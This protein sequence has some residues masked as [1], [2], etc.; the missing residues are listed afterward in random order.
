MSRQPVSMRQA[1]VDDV[2][3]LVELWADGLRRADRQEQVSDLELIVK[4]AEES[5]ERR[6]LVAEYDGEPA[7]AVLLR[8]V[9]I[10]PLNLEPAVQAVAPQVNASFRGKG[11]GSALMEAAVQW[12]EDLGVGHITSAAP[13]GSR[14]GNRFMA[15]LSLGPQA[16]LRASTTPLVRAKLAAMQPASARVTDRVAGRRHLGQLLAARRQLHRRTGEDSA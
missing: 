13:A 2:P 4:E 5:A 11:I 9:P 12:A 14:V 3:F 15:R 16:V 7:G 8:V 10:T 1:T 6:L